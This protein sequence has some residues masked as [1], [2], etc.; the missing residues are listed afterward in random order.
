MGSMMT[1]MVQATDSGPADENRLLDD[2]VH[3]ISELL[4]HRLQESAPAS[5]R[6]MQFRWPPRGLGLEARA[7]AG[8]QSFLRSYFGV[9]VSSL[10]QY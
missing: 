8:E 3:K 6:A 1:I 7:T 9:L 2:V 4:G 5:P 10:I